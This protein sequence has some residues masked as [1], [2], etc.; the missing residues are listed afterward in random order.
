MCAL[1]ARLTCLRLAPPCPC[2]SPPCATVPSLSLRVAA[3]SGARGYAQIHEDKVMHLARSAQRSQQA[4][5]QH[6]P[7][8]DRQQQQQQQRQQRDERYEPQSARDSRH[9]AQQHSPQQQQRQQQQPQSQQQQQQQPRPSTTQPSASASAGGV[10]ALPSADAGRAPTTWIAGFSSMSDQDYRP[11]TA[12]GS[13]GEKT[14]RHRMFPFHDLAADGDPHRPMLRSTESVAVPH[15]EHEEQRAHGTNVINHPFVANPPAYTKPP[16]PRPLSEFDMLIAPE[17]FKDQLAQGEVQEAWSTK[18]KPRYAA[19]QAAT[20]GPTAL[21]PGP[22]AP[23]GGGKGR[24]PNPSNPG[25][26]DPT[27]AGLHSSREIQWTERTSRGI[28]KFKGYSDATSTNHLS[29][30]LGGSVVPFV[31]HAQPAQQ[32]RRPEPVR[33]AIEGHAFDSRPP[34]GSDRDPSAGAGGRVT[35]HR[36]GSKSIAP[37]NLSLRQSHQV[38]ALLAGA[39]NSDALVAEE[40]ERRTARALKLNQSMRDRDWGQHQKGYDIVTL[41]GA[42]GQDGRGPITDVVAQVQRREEDKT[43]AGMSSVAQHRHL[44]PVVAGQGQVRGAYTPNQL[45]SLSNQCD[46]SSEQ[47]YR[48]TYRPLAPSQNRTS[49]VMWNALHGR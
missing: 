48:P 8:G 38:A 18:H 33:D 47:Q 35:E 7:R 11:K 15:P 25:Y 44:I 34:P 12:A 40:S 32:Q 36:V 28:G 6:S 16:P 39:S 19:R 21:D 22:A 30:S 42:G 2:A 43:R 41:A 49:D 9:T 10:R 17:V 5:R 46:P 29:S 26:N 4:S 20:A 3:M 13:G 24:P 23:I 37:Q 14:L 45:S 31:A 1:D 27:R